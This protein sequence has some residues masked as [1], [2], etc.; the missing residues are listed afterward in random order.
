MTKILMLGWELP[1]HNSGGLGEACYFIC[2]NLAA[3]KRV[4]IEFVLP[5]STTEK[6]DFM[7]VHAASQQTGDDFMR[8]Y[9]GVYD[10]FCQTCDSRQCGHEIQINS[11]AHYITFVEQLVKSHS[12]DVIHAHD[13]LTFR[14]GLRAKAL[15]GVPLIAHVHATEFD[16]AG[17]NRGNELI[18]EIE[19]EALLNADAIIAVSNLTKEIIVKEY[20][21]PVSKIQVVHNGIDQSE[22]TELEAENAHHYLEEMKSQGYK[23]VVNLGRLSLQKGV[24]YFL[25]A[26]KLALSKNNK[27]LFLIVGDGELRNEII[28]EAAELGISQNVIFTGFLRGKQRRDSYAIGDIFVMPSV[29]EPFGLTALE[30]ASHHNAVLLSRQSGVSEVLNHTMRFDFWDTQKLADE[31]LA[32]ARHDTLQKMLSDGA[33]QEVASLTWDRAVQKFEAA[34]KRVAG[35]VV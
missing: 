5:Y 24:T 4:K 10:G 29:S 22:F 13:W 2:K 16:R 14:A 21:I 17:G 1:P 11:Q 33:H 30:A 35:V 8:Q 19:A 18:H 34:Y 25:K 15:T 32:V 23:V 9:L 3:R 26:A 12:Y 6:F 20:G 31:I 28:M 27:L 7:H